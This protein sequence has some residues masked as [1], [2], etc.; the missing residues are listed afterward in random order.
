MYYRDGVKGQDRDGS[1][2]NKVYYESKKFP[3]TCSFI[4]KNRSCRSMCLLFLAAVPFRFPLSIVPFSFFPFYP[5]SLRFA[6]L[7]LEDK[8]ILYFS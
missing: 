5:V 7:Y 4:S 8:C 2:C 3:K 1:R 6:S